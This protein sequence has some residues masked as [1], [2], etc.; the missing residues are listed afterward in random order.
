MNYPVL[1][2]LSLGNL[3]ISEM[4]AAVLITVSLVFLVSFGIVSLKND[5]KGMMEWMFDNKTNEKRWILLGWSLKQLRSQENDDKNGIN[6]PYKN[7]ISLGE[8]F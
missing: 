7:L 1:L 5:S 8:G 6:V 2:T 4:S 3:E